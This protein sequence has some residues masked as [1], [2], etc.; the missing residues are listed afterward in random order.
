MEASR[1]K[2]EISTDLHSKVR[3]RIYWFLRFVFFQGVTGIWFTLFPFPI[4]MYTFK[5]LIWNNFTD[6]ILGCLTH[7]T[8]VP[9][10]KNRW[11]TTSVQ[12]NYVVQYPGITDLSNVTSFLSRQK[13]SFQIYHGNVS[14]S[15]YDWHIHISL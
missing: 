14:V 7:F 12:L 5:F 13:S 2:T 8:H 1:V 15:D 4:C 6:V 9:F 11:T 3:V 10:L